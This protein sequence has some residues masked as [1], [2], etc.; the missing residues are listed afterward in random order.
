M[1]KNN[2]YLWWQ[3]GIIYQV[4]PRSYCDSNG[5]GVGDLAG[6]HS[7]LDYLQWLGV[8]AI[9]ISPVYP[10]PM[11]DFG[12]DITD[13][14]NIDPLF[15]TLEEFDL[16]LKDAHAKQLKVILDFVPNHTSDK[17]PWFIESRSSR[18]SPKRNWYIWSD[19]KADGGPPN[20][21]LSVF[22][23]SG[24]EMD[25]AT[26]QF[27]YHAF[28]KEQPDLN[29]RNPQVQEAM[30][31][32]MRFWLERGVDGFR[33]DVI[34]H[35]IKDDQ[36]RDNPPNPHYQPGMPAFDSYLAEHSTDR[37]EV[38]DIIARMRSVLDEYEDR[39]MVGEVYLPISR[40][41]AYY[42][43]GKGTHFPY[44]F[45]LINAAWDAQYLGRI[46]QSYEDALPK[47]GWPNWV[48]GNHDQSRVATRIGQAQARVAAMLLLTL[49]GTPTLY[50]GEEIGM[51]DVPVPKEAIR[52]PFE[53]REPGKGNGRDPER[54]PM[55]WS[56]EANSGFTKGKPWLPISDDFAQVNVEAE[57]D[58]SQSMLTLYHR[59]ITLRRAE[60]ALSVGSYEHF[61]TEGQ[62]LAFKRSFEGKEFLMV[63]NMGGEEATF[64]LSEELRGKIRVAIS[65]ELD[66]AGERPA[67]V[68]VLRRNEGL[69]LETW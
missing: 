31:N 42:G 16:L 15:G 4:Y 69:I 47:E 36:F 56:G 37:P 8:D 19:P 65:T 28:L 26:G 29:W 25:E 7:K 60:S 54:S 62:L 20:N 57:R 45:Q 63:L 14:C 30:L 11:A 67:N 68:L 24:W 66:R 64:L 52:D 21:W 6:I 13:Y 35:M 9:W 59:L 40:L 39:M 46:I 43:A 3:K 49:R 2:G 17:H 5:D 58:D 41:I 38:H 34:Y 50:Y 27:Y 51:H 32:S 10:S 53:I 22:G 23:G 44:N 33:V 55:Q 61:P 1:T 12:Y 48:L 18:T